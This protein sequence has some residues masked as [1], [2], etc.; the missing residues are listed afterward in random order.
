MNIRLFPGGTGLLLMNSLYP[1][2]LVGVGS[3]IGVGVGASVEVGG[4]VLMGSGMAVGIGTG[5]AV[6]VDSNS[7]VGVGM[8]VGIG[9]GSTQK[10]YMTVGPSIVIVI[11]LAVLSKSSGMSPS[12]RRKPM[13]QLAVASIEEPS[14]Y[15]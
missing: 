11:G 5:V 8:T 13:A 7:T 15:S 4:G 6:G 10:A 3:G 1:A 12:Q 2:T 14:K 9:R